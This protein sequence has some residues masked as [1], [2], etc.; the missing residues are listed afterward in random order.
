MGA[1]QPTRRSDDAG[2]P[3]GF[4][5]P[6]SIGCLVPRRRVAVVRGGDE[7]VGPASVLLRLIGELGARTGTRSAPERGAR[8]G[9]MTS[10]PSERRGARLDGGVHGGESAPRKRGGRLQCDDSLPYR[11]QDTACSVLALD[12]CFLSA[13][14]QQPHAHT[15]SKPR[16]PIVSLECCIQNDESLL[17][18]P[19]R[20]R[21]DSP[22]VKS[23]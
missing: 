23:P 7:R 11:K 8:R 13:L 1:R 6:Q 19:E 15:V 2:H 5:V 17:A 9:A 14:C 16:E 18:R 4:A 10:D 3:V 21:R 12:V 20:A 22:Y